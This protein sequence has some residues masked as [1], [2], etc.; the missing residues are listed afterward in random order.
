MATLG[1]PLGAAIH[2]FVGSQQAKAWMESQEYAP[3]KRIRQKASK[4]NMIVIEG[5]Q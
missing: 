2:D 3:A 1:T 5:A 4:S